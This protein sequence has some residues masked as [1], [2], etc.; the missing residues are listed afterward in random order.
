[1]KSELELQMPK[2]ATDEQGKSAVVLDRASYITL[3]IRGNVTDPSY[4]PPG[5]EEG[6]RALARIRQ[7]EHEC[8]AKYGEF[9]WEKLPPEV[10]DEYDALCSLLDRLTDTGERIS[11]SELLT[12][13][14]S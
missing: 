4:W 3:L 14:R 12:E 1:V 13:E 2:F 5:T 9:D 6:A 11:L 10:Q 7:I 8:I